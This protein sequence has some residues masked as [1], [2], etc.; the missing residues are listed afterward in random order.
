MKFKKILIELFPYILILFVM[1]GI[2]SRSIEV[3][4]GNYLFGFDH[5]RE[6]L[7]TK[8]I[9]VKHH[10]P[11]IGTPLGAGSAGINGIFH[12]P[13]YYYFLAIPFILFNG[14]PYGGVVLMF[15][16]GIGALVAGFFLGRRIFG[17]IGGLIFL[18]LLAISPPLI[19]QSRSLWSPYPSTLFII[20][21]IYFTYLFVFEKKW[22]IISIF[23]AAFFAGFVYNFEL[24]IAVPL[25]I[26]LCIL[27]VFIFQ[28]NKLKKFSMLLF[29]FFV[30]YF[31]M[32]LFEIRHN[33]MA[34]HGLVS[35]V[36]TFRPNGHGPTFVQNVVDH[37]GSFA[38]NIVN[39][40]PSQNI[41]SP[42]LFF[43][44]MLLAFLYAMRHEKKLEV[45]IFITYL[46]ALI[47]ITFL[48]LLLLRNT[49]YPNYL[50]HLH[51]VYITVFVYLLLFY[52]RI[53]T[54]NFGKYIF[55]SIFVFFLLVS[56]TPNL[57]IINYDLKDYGGEAKII[58]KK[59]AID[60]IYKDANGKPFSLFIFSPP[61]YTYPYDYIIEWYGVK[62][63]GYL[64]GK[65]KK[66]LFYLLIEVDP[67]KP[68]SYKGWL[69]TVIKSGTVLGE[70]R[71]PSGLIIQ[72]RYQNGQ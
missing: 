40:F 6:Y 60:F 54:K 38:F 57:K 58:G 30:S 46:F 44:I 35:Y 72:K 32:I 64:P 43:V 36:T 39:S 15:L 1:F 65:E 12:G 50:Y 34:V 59:D 23:L 63:F 49:V 4:S 28:K 20:L 27:S 9:V 8:D 61:V 41:I 33:F 71:L 13:G 42:L 68:W 18:T 56:I 10:F 70:T 19:T 22:N 67:S 47:P 24:A 52:N 26:G 31:P 21:S 5:G 14:D 51:I 29:G 69:E 25:A 37:F 62:K 53:K 45:K 55:S 16:Y 7:M 17:N 48:T 11:L 2:F 3:I 66:G